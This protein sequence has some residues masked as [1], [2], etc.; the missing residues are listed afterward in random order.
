MLK[1]HKAIAKIIVSYILPPILP[2]A[3]AVIISLQQIYY[4]DADIFL[5]FNT[6]YILLLAGWV[7]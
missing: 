2:V 5:I 3:V 4:P 6:I 1:T 7:G